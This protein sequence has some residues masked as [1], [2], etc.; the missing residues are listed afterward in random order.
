MMPPKLTEQRV[1]IGN[2]AY[3]R[4]VFATRKTNYDG[5]II[6]EIESQPNSQLDDGD[7]MSGLTD[8]NLRDL[9]AAL[10]CVQR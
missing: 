10:D 1:L 8:E 2:D 3:G 4:R 7:R 5:K 9:I 6:W